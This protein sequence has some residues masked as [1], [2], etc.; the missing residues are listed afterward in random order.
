M[1]L[2]YLLKNAEF[3]FFQICSLNPGRY[4][5][6]L[7]DKCIPSGNKDV[8]FGDVWFESC[9]GLGK[10]FKQCAFVAARNKTCSEED[11]LFFQGVSFIPRFIVY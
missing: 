11:A 2:V 6:C 9:A 8:Y 10:C 3:T 5:K 1:I 7:A 4:Y